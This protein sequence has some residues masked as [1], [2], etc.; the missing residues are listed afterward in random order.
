MRTPKYSIHALIAMPLILLTCLSVAGAQTEITIHEFSNGVD[1]ALPGGALV[2]DGKGN[3]FGVTDG[4][5]GLQTNGTVFELSPATGGG[6]NLTTLY[7][8]LGGLDGN[9]PVAGLVR[10]QAGNLYG[11][12]QTGGNG[13]SSN[14]DIGTGQHGC[15]TIFELSPDGNGGWQKTTLYQFQG[16]VGTRVRDGLF[17]SGSLVLDSAGN[18]YGTTL[19]GG[20]NVAGYGGGTVFELSPNGTGWSEK[21]LVS[22][23]NGEVGS[24]GGAFPEGGVIFDS[25]GNLYGTTEGGGSFNR[26]CIPQGC[27]TVFKLSPKRGGVWGVTPIHTFVG[28][29]G[30][31]P[32]S[33]LTFDSAGNLFGTASW[34]QKLD[35]VVF[36]LEPSSTGWKETVI[37]TFGGSDGLLPSGA[38]VV[39]SGGN[40]YGTT[41][42]GGKACAGKL[43]G[44]GEIF[45]L[46]PSPAGSWS[47]KV[48]YR[49]TGGADGASPFGPLTF[50]DLGDIYGVAPQG[51][52]FGFGT[53]FEITA[54]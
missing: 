6:W 9:Q 35:G 37:H 22:F 52:T 21:I 4:Y 30:A 39:D 15:G 1:G 26:A 45:E 8:F 17:P 20:A 7:T 50:D 12:T 44:C 23:Q 18:L 36:K 48:L 11:A 41:S 51:G 43:S 53:I 34:G 16:I 10:D 13:T 40:V 2:S 32:K 38:L 25:A 46:S 14:C 42:L 24:S 49:F 47:E 3:Y 5:R 28:G 33:A 19:Y 27:G 54:H 31:F 29:D